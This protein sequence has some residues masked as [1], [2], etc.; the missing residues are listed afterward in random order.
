MKVTRSSGENKPRRS[1]LFER[2]MASA[3]AG[4]SMI[5]DADDVKRLAFMPTIEGRARRHNR[6]L[7]DT[8]APE[9]REPH[10]LGLDGG[11]WAQKGR[12]Y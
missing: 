10:R 9:R 3:K 12:R 5:L 8:P 1:S 7:E 4:R 6:V 11:K 2:I